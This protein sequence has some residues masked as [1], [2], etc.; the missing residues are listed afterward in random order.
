MHKDSSVG[1]QGIFDESNA[2]WEAL[3]QVLVLIVVDLDL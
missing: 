2:G 1:I 3:E